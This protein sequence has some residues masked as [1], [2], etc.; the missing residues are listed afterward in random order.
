MEGYPGETGEFRRLKHIAEHLIE[1]ESHHRREEE[2]LF[3]ELERRGVL[4]PPQVMRME[5][6]E[7]RKD[8]EE[9]A[10]LAEGVSQMD[11]SVFKEKLAATVSSI[12]P[13]LREHISKE[14]NIL[15]PMALE[16]IEEDRWAELRAK[17]DEIG[18]CCFIPTPGARSP[19][20]GGVR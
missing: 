10:K 11:S 6:E 8:K 4:G 7:L 15:Y 3:P 5:H 18:Y 19:G 20:R 14:D 17:C 13:T 16:V 12:V 9:L 2:V 1:A